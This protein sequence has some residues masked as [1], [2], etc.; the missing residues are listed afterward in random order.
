MIPRNWSTDTSRDYEFTDWARVEALAHE[1]AE[2]AKARV[3][4]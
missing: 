4:A 1:F 3:A 2:R